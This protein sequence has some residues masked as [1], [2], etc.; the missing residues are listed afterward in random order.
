[1]KMLVVLGAARAGWAARPGAGP[2]AA[3]WARGRRRRT[4]R[5]R[6]PSSASLTVASAVDVAV[7]D[8]PNPAR[9]ARAV[10]V[11]A[12][13]VAGADVVHAHGL[14]AA[15]WPSSRPP[16]AARPVVVT[17]HNAAPSGAVTGAV[18]AVLERLVARAHLVLG[19]SADLVERMRRLGARRTGLAVV[20]A[21]PPAHGG[22]TA[23]QVRADAR[24]R[25]SA[26]LGVVVARLAP[27]KGLDVLLDAH[28]E[29]RATPTCLL[30]VVAGDGPLRD[31]L[32]GRIR[33]ER[34]PGPPARPARRR[35][36][37]ARRRRRR[38]SSAVWEGQ[39]IGL[40]EALHAGAAIVATD[41]GGT[42]RRRRRRRPARAR[43]RRRRPRPRR[44]RR[45]RPRRRP[46]RP[47]LA[48]P[49]AGRAAARPRTTRS[50]RRSPPTAR[51]CRA[52]LL[53]A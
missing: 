29:L 50:P 12:G 10:R 31:A 36:R 24:R 27:Q 21:P 47:A 11:L 35:P 16:A 30:T 8:R 26:A 23:A 4:G 33:D 19:V 43:R 7:A 53:G 5:G 9:D 18:Y 39:P 14:R 34:L 20:P 37:P 46:R 41:A 52:G 49:R 45:G 1:M 13:V 17:L 40:Q 25:A 48:R 6:P 44:A 2:A 15:A 22:R 32:A 51:S 42:A 3:A 38:R 28:R